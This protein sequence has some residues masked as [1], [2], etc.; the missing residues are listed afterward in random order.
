MICTD[1]YKGMNIML[2]ET[3]PNVLLLTLLLWQLWGENIITTV[4]P[5]SLE[6]SSVYDDSSLKKRS[7]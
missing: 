4:K 7:A 5:F 2:L 6:S 3:F 1:Y